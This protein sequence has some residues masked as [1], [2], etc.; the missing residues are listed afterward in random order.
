MAIPKILRVQINVDAI[1]KK[2]LYKGKKGTYLNVA[3]VNTPDSQYGQDYMVT[4]DIPKEARDAG[5]R[6]PI[7]GNASALFLEDG[8]P[9]KKDENAK[10]SAAPVEGDKSD[11]LP[12]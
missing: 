12:F 2:H 7:L 5:E 8:V 6:G 11:D 10:S 9:A 4:Q 3:L 1:D